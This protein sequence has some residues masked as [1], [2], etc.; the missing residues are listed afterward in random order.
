MGLYAFC[1]LEQKT[2]EKELWSYYLKVKAPN[3]LVEFV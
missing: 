2:L 1:D 3:V